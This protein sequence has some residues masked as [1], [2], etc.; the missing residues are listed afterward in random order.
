MGRLLRITLIFL[1][2]V[3]SNWCAEHFTGYALI[4]GDLFLILLLGLA[5]IFAFTYIWRM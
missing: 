1:A 5:A 4:G 3:L 2:V